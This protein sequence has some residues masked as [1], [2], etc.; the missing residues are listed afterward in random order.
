MKGVVMA[1]FGLFVAATT[2]RHA[3]LGTVPVAEAM[4]AIGLL[5]LVA[6]LAVAALLYRYRE[7]DA[8]AL[9]VWLCTRN[10]CIVNL[11]VIAA[12]AG[13][14][15][16]GTPWP[17]IAIAAAIATLGLTSAARIIRRARGELRTPATAA[18]AAF[19]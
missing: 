18:G 6:N 9:S 11:A 13:V 15:A 16:S 19:G 3:I 7:G 1:L 10:D 14:W 2:I 8:Q 12:G 17:D 4:G 5:A